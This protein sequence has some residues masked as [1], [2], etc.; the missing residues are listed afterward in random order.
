MSFTEFGNHRPSKL[1]KAS[2]AAF[3]RKYTRTTKR[4]GT[5]FSFTI[6]GVFLASAAILAQ[7]FLAGCT[8]GELQCQVNEESVCVCDDEWRVIDGNESMVTVC[9]WEYTGK[10]CGR[11]TPPPACTPDY[12]GVTHEFPDEIKECR[13]HGESCRWY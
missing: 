11:Q 12:K 6:I 2:S 4:I 3:I 9:G 13:C 7:E 8:L 5:V 10:S 1:K